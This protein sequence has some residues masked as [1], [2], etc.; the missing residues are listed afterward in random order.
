M[1]F[2]ANVFE[3]GHQSR[4]VTLFARCSLRHLLRLP[5]PGHEHDP[6]ASGHR[7][8]RLQPLLVGRGLNQG[9]CSVA[10]TSLERTTTNR[11]RL[12]VILFLRPT[13]LPHIR[14]YHHRR[15]G[16]VA[17]RRHMMEVLDHRRPCLERL[18]LALATSAATKHTPRRGYRMQLY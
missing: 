13:A 15:S 14:I 8:I 5:A 9:S 3:F 4:S 18:Q 11:P 17:S 6:C 1:G 10:D 16:S 2:I 7:H 12:T